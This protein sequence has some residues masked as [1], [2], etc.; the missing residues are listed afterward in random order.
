MNLRTLLDK[1][2]C[3]FFSMGFGFYQT[4]KADCE[5]GIQRKA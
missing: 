5:A 1:G 4:E 3:A 2:A